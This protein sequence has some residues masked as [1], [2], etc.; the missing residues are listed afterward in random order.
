M[1][2]GHV[3]ALATIPEA[4]LV[5]VCDVSPEV[6]RTFTDQG[7]PAFEKWDDLYASVEADCAILNLPH[8]LYPEAVC[9]ALERGLHVLKEKPF[10]RTLADAERMAA[11]AEASGRTLM[12]AGQTKFLPAF[13]KARELIETGVLGDIFLARYAMIYNWVG[14]RENKWSWRGHRELSGGVAIIDSGYHPLDQMQWFRGRPEAVYA[15]TGKM[16]A[17]PGADYDVDD[18]AVVTL[19]Y[20]DGGIGVVTICFVTQPSENHLL[21]HG[22]EASLDVQGQRATLLPRQGEPEQFTFAEVDALAA[23]QREFLAAIRE[24]RPPL[25]AVPHALQVQQV[26]E[27]AYQSAATGQRIVL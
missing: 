16:K 13:Q 25:G 5:G 12:V 19:E 23:E 27:A 11:A 26:I 21:L 22:T 2:A 14:A 10:A 8:Y 18:K 15:V 17:V 24:N 3:A 6:R 7:L 4:T 1:G 20:P 9:D